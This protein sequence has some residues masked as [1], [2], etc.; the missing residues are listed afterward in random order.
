MVP[1]P[2]GTEIKSDFSPIIEDLKRAYRT[3]IKPLEEQFKF[4]GIIIDIAASLCEGGKCM[5]FIFYLYCSVL[6]LLQNSTLQV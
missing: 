3:K 1:T 2:V 5:I 4:Q 6:F